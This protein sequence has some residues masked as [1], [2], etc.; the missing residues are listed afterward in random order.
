MRIDVALLADYAAITREGKLLIC[1]VFDQIAAMELPW[2][3]PT[4]T[5]V[6]RVR[7]SSEEVGTHPVMVRGIDPDGAEFIPALEGEIKVED[8]DFLDGAATNF[9][10]GINGVLLPKEGHY[11]FD[12]H[13]DGRYE[14]SVTFTVKRSEQVTLAQE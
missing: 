8:T 10:L 12:L 11:H 3:H 1:G 13:I 5:L 6:F 9:M 14:E 2:T 4:M 7:V